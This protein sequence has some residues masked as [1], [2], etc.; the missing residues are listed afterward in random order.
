MNT[1]TNKLTTQ[2]RE[3]HP[4][5][6]PICLYRQEVF[7]LPVISPGLVHATVL[8]S[9][10]GK[11]LAKSWS[12][13]SQFY[14][15]LACCPERN[16][17]WH[18]WSS[19]LKISKENYVHMKR[20]Q[21]PPACC[22]GWAFFSACFS[23]SGQLA[24][25]ECSGDCFSLGERGSLCLSRA[26]PY[27]GCQTSAAWVQWE[28]VGFKT[29]IWLYQREHQKDE[30]RAWWLNLK[31]GYLTVFIGVFRDTMTMATLIAENT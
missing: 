21:G 6:C 5:P 29:D 31:A 27:S 8:F 19:T 9:K 4:V 18:T 2:Q 20:K 30:G 7:P 23:V 16:A 11:L 26:V 12:L 3:H 25:G 24:S 10:T 28:M 14:S 13:V 17:F 1:V 22:T 15:V